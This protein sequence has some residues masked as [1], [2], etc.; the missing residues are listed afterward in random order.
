MSYSR[1]KA[2]E[3]DTS[4]EI[5]R[6]APTEPRQSPPKLQ[7]ATAAQLATLFSAVTGLVQVLL[8]LL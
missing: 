6:Q 2:H 3:V 7:L 4:S 1:H 5:N 8:L